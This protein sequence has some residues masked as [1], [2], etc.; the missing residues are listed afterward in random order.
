[1]SAPPVIGFDTATPR[2][3]VAATA[4]G[5]VLF[6]RSSVPAEGERP[7]HA[8]ELLAAVEAAAEAA[9]GWDAVGLI[10]V[11]IGPGSYTGLRIGISTAR[12]LAQALSK[13][14]APVV[15]LRAL[16]HGMR[17]GDGEAPRLAVLDARRSQIFAALYAPAGQELWEPFVATP[18]QAAE[19]VAG[20]AAT[21]LTAGDGSLRFRRQLEAAGAQVLADDD[22]AHLISGRHVC[23]LAIDEEPARPAEVQP[24]YLRPPDAELWREQQRR[25]RNG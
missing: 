18:E 14:L 23:A 17:T 22:E 1:M 15:S 3:T 24:I 6:E 7:A 16:A 13:P 9:G 5:E 11:G 19:R 21:P 4:A 12:G 8:R 20:L 25:D 2:L 10:A